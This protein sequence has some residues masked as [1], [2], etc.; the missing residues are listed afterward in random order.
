[1]NSNS[2]VYSSY[3]VVSKENLGPLKKN[4]I[5]IMQV[6]RIPFAGHAQDHHNTRPQ[7]AANHEGAHVTGILLLA[8]TTTAKGIQEPNFTSTLFAPRSHKGHPQ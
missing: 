3:R 1:M 8:K 2:I 4:K 6:D 7:N 5:N